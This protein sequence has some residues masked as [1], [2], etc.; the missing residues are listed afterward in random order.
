[1][2]E[3]R[4]FNEPSEVTGLVGR[5]MEERGVG[6]GDQAREFGMDFFATNIAMH[7]CG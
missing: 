6:K 1:M 2:R 7:Q 4:Q 3:G 5:V